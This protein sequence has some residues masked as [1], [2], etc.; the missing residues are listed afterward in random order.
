MSK[1]TTSS[2]RNSRRLQTRSHAAPRTAPDSLSALH[3]QFS[4]AIVNHCEEILKLCKQEAE[5][6]Y[7]ISVQKNSLTIRSANNLA[8]TLRPDGI[9]SFELEGRLLAGFVAELGYTQS[10]RDLF[11]RVSA[12]SCA[13][14]SSLTHT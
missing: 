5:C 9:I 1:A 8:K 13:I 3:E 12:L 4:D 11:M 6:E 14:L 10:L 7:T 2:G